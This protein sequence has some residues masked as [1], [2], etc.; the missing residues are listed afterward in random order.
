VLDLLDTLTRRA[1]K[2]LLMVTHSPDVVGLADRVFRMAEGHLVEEL[3]I[4][5]SAFRSQNVTLKNTE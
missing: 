1:G 3:G 2:N 5:E 4:Q